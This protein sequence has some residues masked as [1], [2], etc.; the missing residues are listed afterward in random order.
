MHLQV[1]FYSNSYITN[2]WTDVTGVLIYR[3]S[4]GHPCGPEVLVSPDVLPWTGNVPLLLSAEIIDT[5]VE[6]STAYKYIARPV[7]TGTNDDCVL[8]YISTGP[9]LVQGSFW[10]GTQ[11]CGLANPTSVSPC[12]TDCFPFALVSY[13]PEAAPYINTGAGLLIY[14][15]FNGT[16]L[17]CHESYPV[18][19]I[20]DVEEGECGVVG[21]ETSTWGAVK[22]KYR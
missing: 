14:G 5:T 3:R 15:E 20:T 19:N 10:Q 18:F 22:S 13:P 16:A 17:D 2:C 4:V 1:E 7:G 8:G 11:L 21:V 12:L 9:S 6:P